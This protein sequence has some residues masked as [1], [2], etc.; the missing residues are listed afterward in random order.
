MHTFKNALARANALK[1]RARSAGHSQEAHVSTPTKRA[2]SA[3]RHRLDASADA[4]MPAS[5]PAA[6]TSS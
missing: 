2:T 4:A 6:S 5:R 1:S 3:S